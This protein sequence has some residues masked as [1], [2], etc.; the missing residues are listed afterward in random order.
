VQVFIDLV[1]ALGFYPNGPASHKA[2]PW[3][4]ALPQEE[5]AKFSYAT[6]G[7]HPQE[8]LAKFRRVTL[9]NQS[10]ARGISQIFR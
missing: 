10:S 6:L 5:L 8:K 1:K 4:Q 2:S 7:N 3:A 9:G